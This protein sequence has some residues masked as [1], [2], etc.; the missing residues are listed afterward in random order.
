MKCCSVFTS[1]PSF[2]CDQ[3][4]TGVYVLAAAYASREGSKEIT[5]MVQGDAFCKSWLLNLGNA[6][7]IKDCQEFLQTFIPAVLRTAA[8][9]AAI[10]GH[11]ICNQAFDDLCSLQ[12]YNTE[13]IADTYKD[14]LKEI[15]WNK[16][17]NSYVFNI[18]K[19][20][21]YN[22]NFAP[23]CREGYKKKRSNLHEKW[24]AVIPESLWFLSF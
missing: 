20:F 8:K 3:C 13:E 5:K 10:F 6:K 21:L 17:C 14:M 11:K 1:Q 4:K 16:V 9:M 7:K 15:Q 18:W 2:D 22:A 19:C 12:P 24:N 23:T